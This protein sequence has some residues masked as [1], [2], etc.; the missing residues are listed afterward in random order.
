M[1]LVFVKGFVGNLG[2]K[3]LIENKYD[4]LS[5]YFNAEFL[6][7]ILNDINGGVNP[8][9]FMGGSSVSDSDIETDAANIIVDRENI[10][11][12]GLLT[13]LWKICD[14]NKCGL[15]YTL[16]KV[17]IFQGTIEISNYFDLNP[18]RLLTNNSEI[19]LVDDSIEANDINKNIAY[20]SLIGHTTKDKKRVRIDNEI[21]SF[22]T[23]DY[24]DEIDRIIPGFI[25]NYEKHSNSQK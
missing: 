5:E 8:P 21:E 25:K 20:G 7:K 2:T 3:I 16:S 11:R 19:L 22:L 18:Y 6:K 15:R 17:P 13:A 4:E 12:G 1:A 23:K 9:L 24:K 14:R 10:T